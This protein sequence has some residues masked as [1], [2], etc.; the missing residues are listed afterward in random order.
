MNRT[1]ESSKNCAGDSLWVMMLIE[2]NLWVMMLI[3]I[4]WGVQVYIPCQPPNAYYW[5]FLDKRHLAIVQRKLSFKQETCYMMTAQDRTNIKADSKESDIISY[6]HY[7]IMPQSMG[8]WRLRQQGHQI[9]Q[10]KN[11]TL[12]APWPPSSN[13]DLQNSTATF[14]TN[15]YFYFYITFMILLLDN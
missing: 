3:E 8:C 1:T 9:G 2:M 5:N 7:W 15:W 12:H 14:S 4:L 10:A 13:V 6:L 11:F